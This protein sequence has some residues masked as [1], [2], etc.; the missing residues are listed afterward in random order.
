MG[1]QQAYQADSWG[2]PVLLALLLCVGA[3][4]GGCDL[5]FSDFRFVEDAGDASDDG[6]DA[7]D[8]GAD[9][10][11]K[12][13][14][15]DTDFA[16]PAQDDAFGDEGAVVEEEDRAEPP[17]EGEEAAEPVEEAVE[18]VPDETA[19][20][21]EPEGEAE[22]VEEI[23]EAVADEPAP[24]PEVEP[25]AEPDVFDVVEE[26]ERL[27]VVVEPDAVDMVEEEGPGLTAGFVFIPAGGFTMGSPVGEP[28]RYTD[29][30]QHSVTLTI[31][32][33]MMAREV[34]QSEFQA[35]IGRTPSYFPGCGASCP[36]E[37]VN[38]HEAL[39]YANLF[40]AAN[41]KAQCFDC[42]GSTTT[43]VT[44][45]LKT[46]Y[47]R[48]QDC[49]GYRL[50]TEAEWEYAA[51]AGSTTAFYNGGITNT[52]RSP[53]DPNLDLIGW[54]GGNSSVTY[55][56]GYNC[57]GWFTGATTCG[58]QPVGGKTAN[59]WGLFDISG[60]VW[61]WVWDWYRSDYQLLTGTDPVNMVAG[62]YRVLR[63]GSWYDSASGCRSAGRSHGSPGVRG[64]LIG[65]RLARSW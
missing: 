56:G 1:R 22:P 36:V 52:G 53:L 51:R 59:G 62:S 61:E 20:E 58:T 45:T 42:T 15:D 49:P 14:G 11:A 28:G 6:L 44:C 26:E 29:E 31:S 18:I 4:E 9:D 16:D 8:S 48:P 24:E 60:N 2:S 5:F 12:E 37:W 39:D 13:D 43:S 57:S 17:V 23:V 25:E 46:A 35:R 40:S 34:T 10:G 33:E 3:V 65:F 32:F 50:P 21:P 27:E 47:T 19:P 63:G 55:T 64:D 41:G 7:R 38:W 54:Y 30:T